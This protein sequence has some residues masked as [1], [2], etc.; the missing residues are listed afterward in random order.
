MYLTTVVYKYEKTYL[1]VSAF[2][3]FHIN[4]TLLK[5][6]RYLL[7]QLLHFICAVDFGLWIMK[8]FE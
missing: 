1:E 8:R 2:F 5:T 6:T 4:S 7:S 3:S